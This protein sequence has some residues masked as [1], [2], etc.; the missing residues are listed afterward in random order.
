MRP[1]CLVVQT[2]PDR[3]RSVPLD[4]A[5]LTI[6]RGQDQR[7]QLRDA[8]V[9]RHHLT[10]RPHP[11]GDGLELAEIAGVNPC[12]TL[13][14]GARVQLKAGDAIAVGAAFT[15]GNTTL[16]L[17]EIRGAAEAGPARA[18]R[19]KR[20]V[21]LDATQVIGRPSG[22]NRLA[23]LAALGDRLA[24]CGSLQAVYR[25]ATDWALE[26]IQSTRALLLTSEGDDILGVASAGRVGDLALSSAILRRVQSE[27]RAFLLGDLLAEPDLA[28]RRSVQARGIVGAMAAPVEHLIFYVEW[29][30][31]EAARGRHSEEDLLLLVCAAQLVAAIGDSAEERKQLKAAA[32]SRAGGS[33]GGGRM[34]GASAAMRKLQVFLERVAATNSTVLLL[35]ESGTGKELAAGT[36]HALSPR[37]QAPFVAINCAAIAE[38]LLESELFG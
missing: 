25:T 28:D 23:A 12:W 24:R 5:P 33:S 8:A 10:V 19:S 38:N 27:R 29:G 9:S 34:I 37:A 17:E 21:E 18:G 32:R 20:T 22:G 30:P 6:G 14:E 2:G 4:G 31:A 26:A 3:G 36:I 7:L 11:R 16:R 35:G 15:L 1:L 13:R